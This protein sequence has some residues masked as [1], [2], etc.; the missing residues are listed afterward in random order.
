MDSVNAKRVPRSYC[1]LNALHGHFGTFAIQHGSKVCSV[2]RVDGQNEKGNADQ[3][4]FTSC[5]YDS[6]TPSTLLCTKHCNVPTLKDIPNDWDTFL[7]DN[8]I[9]INF[10]SHDDSLFYGVH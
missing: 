10:I 3:I 8:P 4:E 2:H 6:L 7:S 1:V 9:P 5:G